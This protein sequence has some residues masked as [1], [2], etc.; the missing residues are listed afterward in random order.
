MDLILASHG[1]DKKTNKT[2]RKEIEKAESIKQQYFEDL[3]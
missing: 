3:K 1:L 2:P